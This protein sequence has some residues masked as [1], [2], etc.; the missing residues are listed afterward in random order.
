[1][2]KIKSLIEQI[3]ASTKEDVL[4]FY[5]E[6][7]EKKFSGKNEHR[8]VNE[9]T[10][11]LLRALAKRE[12]KK[13][14][15]YFILQTKGGYVA[16][17]MTIISAL[18]Q[19]YRNIHFIVMTYAGSAGAYLSLCG[20]T[21]YMREASFLSDFGPQNWFEG[22][23]NTENDIQE[24][25]ESI[26]LLYT[27]MVKQLGKGVCKDCDGK[28]L[29]DVLSKLGGP[30]LPSTAKV[31]KDKIHGT[32]LTMENLQQIIPHNIEDYKTIP[33]PGNSMMYAASELAKLHNMLRR[34]MKNDDLAK[35]IIYGGEDS[36]LKFLRD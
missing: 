27:T 7:S 21:V 33:A 13:E 32:P 12:N 11:Q 2:D 25:A 24:K 30:A 1:M 18:R 28:V 34:K 3:E 8:L 26:A 31:E 14:N 10:E 6:I 16:E 9:D 22:E 4:V 19:H 23:I 15:L 29:P 36:K 17:A 20:D 35:V 5:S